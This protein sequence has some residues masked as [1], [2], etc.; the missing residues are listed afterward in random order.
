MGIMD[1]TTFIKIDNNNLYLFEGI[2]LKSYKEK[3]KRKM[4]MIIRG[5]DLTYKFLIN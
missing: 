2:I 3:S 5:Y 1:Y 4:L